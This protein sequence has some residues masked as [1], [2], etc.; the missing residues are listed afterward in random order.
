MGRVL[1]L[2]IAIVLLVYL[3]ACFRTSHAAPREGVSIALDWNHFILKAE[4]NTEGYRGPVAAR[5]YGYIGLAAYEAALPGMAG[6]FQS[7]VRLYPD[8]KLPAPPAMEHFNL[9]A[10]LNACYATILG[11]FFMSSPDPIINE[12][13]Q[14]LQKW[15]KTLLKEVDTTSYRLSKEFGIGVALRFIIGHL[16]TPWDLGQTITIMT[17]IIFLQWEKVCGS[18]QRISPCPHYYHIGVKCVPF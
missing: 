11:K 9:S 2:I 10:S 18:L 4:I 13:L 7:L 14:L 5:A 16:L 15:E 1:L 17:G 12:Q 3:V 8:L 6:H